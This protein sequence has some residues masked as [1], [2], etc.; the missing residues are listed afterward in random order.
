MLWL[1]IQFSI[2][3]TTSHTGMAAY[4]F[5]YGYI[6]KIVWLATWGLLIRCHFPRFIVCPKSLFHN[7]VEFRT[8]GS[9]KCCVTIEKSSFPDHKFHCQILMMRRIVYMILYKLIYGIYKKY[10]FHQRLD[11]MVEPDGRVVAF[12]MGLYWFRD[13]VSWRLYL[14][15]DLH[16]S[17]QKYWGFVNFTNM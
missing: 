14:T 3:I 11:L 6:L 17:F 5:W 7:Q 8:S 1:V 13:C 16:K 9:R 4:T 2:S 15:G 10:I 12:S